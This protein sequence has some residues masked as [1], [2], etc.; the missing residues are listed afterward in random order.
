MKNRTFRIIIETL[1]CALAG[2]LFG[3]ALGFAF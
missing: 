1:I 2:V 3:V